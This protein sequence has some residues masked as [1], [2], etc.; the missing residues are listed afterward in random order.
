MSLYLHSFHCKVGVISH[1]KTVFPARQETANSIAEVS[2]RLFPWVRKRN[3]DSVAESH[4]RRR[5]S[6]LDLSGAADARGHLIS[7]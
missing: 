4:P 1:A 5:K 3:L 6:A 7:R 2:I